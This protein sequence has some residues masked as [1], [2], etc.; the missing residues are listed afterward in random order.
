MVV[1]LLWRR[2][3]NIHGFILDEKSYRQSFN[4]NSNCARR[5]RCEGNNVAFMHVKSHYYRV[6]RVEPCHQLGGS[7]QALFL[8]ITALDAMPKQQQQPQ[9]SLF[10][11]VT[12]YLSKL[13]WNPHLPPIKIINY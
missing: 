2:P 1:S 10:W 5:F 8:S 9:C 13:I 11:P 6:R 3:G 7:S 12:S 4:S